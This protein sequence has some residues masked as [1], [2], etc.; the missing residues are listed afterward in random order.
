MLSNDSVVERKR[1]LSEIIEQVGHLDIL[2]KVEIG[3]VGD[4][5]PSGDNKRELEDF[6][7]VL[8]G[9]QSPGGGDCESTGQLSGSDPVFRGAG[10]HSQ[11][12]LSEEHVIGK[13]KVVLLVPSV[14][15]LDQHGDVF[16]FDMEALQ[17]VS[18]GFLVQTEDDIRLF[19]PV[20]LSLI[21]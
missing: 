17:P 8:G 14:K 5:L 1:E 13:I 2:D 21:D 9:E 19:E 3:V 10:L 12:G 18:S 11:I 7:R 20:L 15:L 6:D 4:R 16:F